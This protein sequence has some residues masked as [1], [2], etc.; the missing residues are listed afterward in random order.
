[1]KAIICKEKNFAT[2]IHV[3]TNDDNELG[4]GFKEK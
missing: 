1:M 4:W 2:A 3:D